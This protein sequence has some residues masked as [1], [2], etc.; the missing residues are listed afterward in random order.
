MGGWRR[1]CLRRHFPRL[2]LWVGAR[3]RPVIRDRDHRGRAG[4]EGH[5]GDPCPVVL[6]LVLVSSFVGARV[7]VGGGILAFFLT[8]QD[9]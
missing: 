7:L 9:S 6:V 1:R 4:G 3:T 2:R 5:L 8:M